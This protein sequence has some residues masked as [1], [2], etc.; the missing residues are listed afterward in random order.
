[1]A[2]SACSFVL[3]PLD[4]MIEDLKAEFAKGD[5]PE[6]SA[7]QK[8]MGTYIAAGHSDWKE[9]ALFCQ[10]KYAR[11]L[12][13]FNENF[14]LIILCWLPGQESPIHNHSV[15]KA[16]K[17]DGRLEAASAPVPLLSEYLSFRR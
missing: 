11:N 3:T 15:R 14:E 1:M 4:Q 6:P 10:L 8:I 5:K 12:I 17:N 13:E 16:Q 9:F 7:V 2:T